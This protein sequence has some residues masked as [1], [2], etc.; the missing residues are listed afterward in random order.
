MRL[1]S[2][3]KIIIAGSFTTFKGVT[4]NRILRLSPSGTVDTSFLPNPDGIPGYNV[5]TNNTI[6]NLAV[7]PNDKIIIV[8]DFTQFYGITVNRIARLNLDGTRDVSFTTNSGTSANNSVYAISVQQNGTAL[9]GGLLTSFNDV[10][11]NLFFR[12][13]NGPTY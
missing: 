3:G 12:I 1:Q 7:L 5:G 2:D 11:K 4:A 13:G 10:A 8:G 9:I 6:I